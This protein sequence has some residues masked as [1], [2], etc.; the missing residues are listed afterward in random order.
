[1][2]SK[3]F[4]YPQVGIVTNDNQIKHLQHKLLMYI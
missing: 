1:M 2:E 3:G 4:I